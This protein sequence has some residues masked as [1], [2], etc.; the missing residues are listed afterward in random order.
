M[1]MP[2]C[3]W[4]MLEGEGIMGLAT[5]MGIG[6]L[7]PSMFM[8]GELT[9]ALYKLGGFF[10]RGILGDLPV[11]VLERRSLSM[12]CSLCGDKGVECGQSLTKKSSSSINPPLLLVRKGSLEREGNKSVMPFVPSNIIYMNVVCVWFVFNVSPIYKCLLRS[13]TLLGV[14]TIECP[15]I[16]PC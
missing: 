8:V 9:K 14:V 1:G 16:M 12:G 3:C 4:G 10:G 13:E 2:H 15:I 6:G 7:I 11:G 5:I